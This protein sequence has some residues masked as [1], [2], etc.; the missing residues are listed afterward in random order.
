MPTLSLTVFRPLLAW[1]A[2]AALALPASAQ[3]PVPAPMEGVVNLTLATPAA[4]VTLVSFARI[5]DGT[6]TWT[7]A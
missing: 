1:L 2:A 6:H 7:V 4:D 3:T 5:L